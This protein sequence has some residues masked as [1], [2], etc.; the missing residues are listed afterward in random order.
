[1]CSQRRA[2]CHRRGTIRASHERLPTSTD[3]LAQMAD[4]YATLAETVR[5]EIDGLGGVEASMIEEARQL[6]NALREREANPKAKSDDAQ[7]AIT[8][9]NKYAALLLR[10]MNLVR[11]AARFVFRNQPEI[12]RLATSS[13]ERSRRRKAD[14]PAV[15]EPVI[16]TP[17]LGASD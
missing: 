16:A 10:R 8:E 4:E 12:V 3:A 1:M 14:K 17:E 5:A 7:V 11:S 2:M 15:V 13:Y 6:A 9:R